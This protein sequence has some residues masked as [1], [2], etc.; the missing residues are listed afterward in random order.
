MRLTEVDSNQLQWLKEII[1]LWSQ[2]LLWTFE[3]KHGC[4]LEM[5]FCE[6]SEVMLSRTENFHKCG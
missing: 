2:A 3:M 5:V 4:S 1:I 6:I